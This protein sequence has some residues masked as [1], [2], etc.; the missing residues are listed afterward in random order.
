M[1]K[2]KKQLDENWEMYPV[3]VLTSAR[4][5]EQGMRRLQR[6]CTSF[7]NLESTDDGISKYSRRPQVLSEQ[8][9]SNMLNKNTSLT[10][11]SIKSV[12]KNLMK[13]IPLKNDE[14][15]KLQ[16]TQ[17]YKSNS[18]QDSSK[19]Y[20]NGSASSRNEQIPK[21]QPNEQPK[22]VQMQDSV[23]HKNSFHESA[24][25]SN[26]G[27]N[28]SLQIVKRPQYNQ[29]RKRDGNSQCSK[30]NSSEESSSYRPSD[31]YDSTE[32]ESEEEMRRKKKSKTMR[33]QTSHHST[34]SI[35][36]ITSNG[37]NSLHDDKQQKVV[38]KRGKNISADTSTTSNRDNSL[39]GKQHQIAQK[40][41]KNTS[42]PI[43][44]NVFNQSNR[45]FKEGKTNNFFLSIKHNFQLYRVVPSIRT[46]IHV[47][48]E[49]T[50]LN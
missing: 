14:I 36:S 13:G 21:K 34:T 45:E 40:Q 5:L 10:R 12:K 24:K 1:D 49:L 23:Y 37:D 30:L 3:K 19:N 7:Y 20:K 6:T 27:D 18:F 31:R 46:S 26:D 11:Q 4:N 38:K 39:H 25:A 50:K 8:A 29:K 47:Q 35:S 16:D 17:S 33:L 2:R 42:I 41:G 28:E 44:K 9:I 22:N 43:N 32:I 15:T 48:V